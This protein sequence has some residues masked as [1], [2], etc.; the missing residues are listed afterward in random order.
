MA[1]RPK[2]ILDVRDDLRQGREPFS[3]IMAT[4][5]EL[6]FEQDLVLI[7]PLEPVP[8]FAVMA[9]RGFGYESHR[10]ESGD[11]EVRFSRA[12]PGTSSAAMPAVAA[13]GPAPSVDLDVRG[14]EPP[15]PMVRILESLASLSRGG[16]LHARTDRRP[17]HLFPQLEVRGFTGECR[18]QTDGTFVTHIS[19]R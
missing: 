17:M 1:S 15:L 13:P 14:L 10:T 2:L 12:L 8:L 19:R 11:F 3:R 7:A 6:D 5:E 9:R 18:E 16:V 4:V